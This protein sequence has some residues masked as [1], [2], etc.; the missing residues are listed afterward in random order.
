MTAATTVPAKQDFPLPT[1]EERPAA[2]VVI[3]DG[4]CRFCWSQVRKLHR[5]DR[6]GRLAFVSLHDP[7]VARDYPDLSHDDLMNQMYVVDRAG[8]RHG[9]ASA[10]RYLS[11]RLPLLW[12]IAPLLHIPLSLPV[13]RWFYK[14]VAKRRY[15]LSKKVVCD[16]DACEVHFR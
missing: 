9:G 7:A 15:Q 10:V 4:N 3:F 1:R 13:W 5:W 14:Q 11:R 6:G 2:D 8:R 16:G 12:I